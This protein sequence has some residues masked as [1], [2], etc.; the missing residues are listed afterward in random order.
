MKK[1]FYGFLA[2]AGLAMVSCSQEIDEQINANTDS[3]KKIFTANT[4]DGASTRTSIALE[5]QTGNYVV[6]WSGDE[7]IAVNG[8]DYKVIEGA[9]TKS[10][11]FGA[12]V[13]GTEAADAEDYN[14][15][16]PNNAWVEGGLNLEHLKEQTALNAT[17]GH[18]YA[19]TVA[20]T[21][22]KEMDFKFKNAL[23]SDDRED[24]LDKFYDGKATQEDI[25]RVTDKL[26][27]I[28]AQA[29]GWDF[30]TEKK[31]RVSAR[32]AR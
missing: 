10:V 23:S 11:T 9:G 12:D 16:Y 25:D 24:F 3:V 6:I 28:I 7:K 4:E 17:Y 31:E 32:D 26:G 2:L 20:T 30:P 1:I 19:V 14:A 22:D 18:G 8:V 5:E 15:V 21:T 29:Y 13:E 27:G